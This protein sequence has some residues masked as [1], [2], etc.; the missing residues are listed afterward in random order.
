MVEP[1]TET[2]TSALKIRKD[3]TTYGI[4][5]VDL[6]SAA[7]S[8]LKIQTSSGIKAFAIE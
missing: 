3:S 7:A 6:A 5:L 4:V 1:S 2:L 8:N